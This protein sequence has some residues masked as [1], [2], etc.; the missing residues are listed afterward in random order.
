MR[1]R[2]SGQRGLRG[3]QVMRG[4]DSWPAADVAVTTGEQRPFNQTGSR[5]FSPKEREHTSCCEEIK[6]IDLSA[7]AVALILREGERDRESD[8]ESDR[9]RDR[10][11]ERKRETER[12]TGR[13]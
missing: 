9:E 7:E 11:R 5:G 10:E 6:R 1:L 12:V 13:E 2:P 3:N 8:R 4:G